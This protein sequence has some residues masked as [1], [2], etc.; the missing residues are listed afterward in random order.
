MLQALREKTT[1]LIAKIILGAIV[2]AFS[3]FGIES[4]FISQIDSFVARVGDKEISQQEFRSRFDEFRQ[5]RLQQAQGQIDARMFEQPAIK[6]QFLESLIDEKVLMTANERLGAV[7]PDVRLQREILQIPAFQTNGVFDENLYRARLAAIGKTPVSF[8]NDIAREMAARELP[9]AVAGSAF[10]TEAE[11]DQFLRL[12]G[13]L[14][15][16]RYVSL[17]RPESSSSEVGDE[18]ISAYYTAHQQDYMHPEQVSLNYVELDAQSLDVQLNPDESTL[19]DRY[20]KDKVRYVTSEQRLASHI[21][22]K[23]GGDGGPDE[24]KAALQKATEIAGQLKAGKDFAEL[25]KT[26]SDDLGSRALGGDLGWLDKGMTD[27]AFEEALYKLDKG[28]VSDPVL[29]SEGYHII[30][31]RDIRPGKTRSFDEVREE[32]A[33][34]YRQTERE[35]V[36]NER[37]GRLIDLSYADSTSLDPAASELGLTVQ[38]TELF[39][40]QGGSGIAANPAIVTAAFSDQVLAQGNNSDKIELG[41]EHIAI[42][43]IL[44]HKPATP[45]L[46]DDVRDD[47]RQRII[48]E[49]VAKQAKERADALFA[50]LQGGEDLEKIATELGLPVSQEKAIGRNAVNLDQNL[51]QGAFDLPRPAADK[52][53]YSLVPLFG[54]RYALLMLD[55]VT[56]ADP[57]AVEAPT[58]EAARNSLAQAM[59]DASAR[60]FIAALRASMEIEVVEE[61]M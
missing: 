15:D 52:P 48:S 41:P 27:P 1:G 25:A 37:S 23:V 5:Q 18:E 7:I 13:Q 47:I 26:S 57:A 59:A 46:L 21:L 32:L 24:Q 22:V 2:I 56:D 19:R 50:R 34:E 14:R 38:K 31:A 54:D 17:E 60:E 30:Q 45:K 20:E 49:R 12:R 4:Y 28:A 3:F 58:R 33:Q 16:F 42:V 61:R 53:S 44:E 35:R 40:R 6:R 39:D 43:R 29:S 11:V 10:V 51:V 9:V 55:N 8:A 36:Y